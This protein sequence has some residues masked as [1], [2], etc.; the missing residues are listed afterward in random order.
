MLNPMRHS[1]ISENDQ[2]RNALQSAG[3]DVVDSNP[4][5]DITHEKSMVV[6]DATAFVKSL[7]WQTENLT[8]YPRLC[9]HHLGTPHEVEEI[10]NGFE[11]DWSRQDFASGKKR[12]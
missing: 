9:H 8:E 3:I 4:A 5:F 10:I 12:I 7:N 1:G 6:D 2:S 11:A